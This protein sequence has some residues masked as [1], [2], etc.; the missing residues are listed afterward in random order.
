MHRSVTVRS[1][2]GTPRYNRSRRF[3]RVRIRAI[4]HAAGKDP[5]R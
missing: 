2:D 4:A 5:R 1:D 3:A